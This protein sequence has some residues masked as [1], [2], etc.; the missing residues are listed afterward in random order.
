M[1]DG[2]SQREMPANPVLSS[3]IV[4]IGLNVNQLQFPSWVPNP[5][6]LALLTGRQYD[7]AALLPSLLEACRLRYER[8][9]A[10]ED[11]TPEY[12]SRL[13]NLGQPRRY[14]Y[15]GQEIEATVTGVDRFGRLLLTAADGTH[16]CCVMKEIELLS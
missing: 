3:S 5:T 6:S 7:V 14:L 11:P 16:L 12:L 9:R 8:I 1:G 2:P 15:G 13:M 10:G 4:G